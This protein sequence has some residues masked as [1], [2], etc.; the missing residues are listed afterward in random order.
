[1][2][3]P[4]DRH[5]RTEEIDITLARDSRSPARFDH[6]LNG[7][8]GVLRTA[9]GRWSDIPV[10]RWH[11]ASDDTADREFDDAVV[12][13]CDGPTIDLGCGPGRLV[14]ALVAGDVPA[15][16][17]DI[18]RVA[19]S[20]AR[21]RGVAVLQRDIFGHLPGEGRWAHVLLIDGNIGIGGDPGL[22]LERV[23]A[24]LARGGTLIAELDAHVGGVQVDVVRTEG[25]HGAGPWFPWARVGVDG[26]AAAMRGHGLD[27]L[28]IT[29][30]SGRLLV[31]AV[32]R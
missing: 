4:A 30:I 27:P 6:A 25:R 18:S 8:H 20:A 31:E 1:M 26:M 7:V 11:G 13:R 22:L 3:I 29:E 2:T 21:R 16:G 10:A 32:R 15:L 24:L 9:D 14:A 23:G 5:L 12:R 17:V 19:V 28:N